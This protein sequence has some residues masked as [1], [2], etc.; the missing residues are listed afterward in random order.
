MKGHNFSLIIIGYGLISL[1]MMLLLLFFQTM[2]SFW[3]IMGSVLFVGAILLIRKERKNRKTD[4]MEM[5]IMDMAFS[6]C[7]KCGELRFDKKVNRCGSC[8]SEGYQ[9]T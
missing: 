3:L 5:E 4:M 2:G 1:A 6:R 8:G 9:N 7:S